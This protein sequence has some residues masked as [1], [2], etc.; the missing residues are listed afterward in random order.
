MDKGGLQVGALTDKSRWRYSQGSS[1]LSDIEEIKSRDEWLSVAKSFL[2]NG[3]LDYI[4]LGCAPGQYTAAISDEME[5]RVSGIDYS[6]DAD[7]FLDTMA[8]FN[9]ESRLYQIDMFEEKIIEKFDIV[10]SF[11]LIEH[12]RGSKLDAVLALHDEY[13]RRGGYLVICV[14]NFTGVQ[15]LWHYVFD[16]PDLDRHNIDVMQPAIF[17]W[18]RDMGY[19]VLFNDYVGVVR[20]WGNSGWLRWRFIGKAVAGL[21]VFTSKLALLLDKLGITLRGRTWSPALLFVAKKA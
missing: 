2:P 17:T 6:D 7:L 1:T 12:F 13:L 4:E 20:L 10:T 21:A 3:D 16:R 11:G 8:L 5:W 19:E 9:K 18:Y 14:T 15:Y